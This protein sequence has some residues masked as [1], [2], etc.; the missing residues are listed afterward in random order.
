MRMHTYS[1]LCTFVKTR[2]RWPLRDYVLII[3]HFFDFPVADRVV[4]FAICKHIKKTL[5]I[6]SDTYSGDH[7]KVDVCLPVPFS[8]LTIGVI[9]QPR[10]I[11]PLNL[12][13]TV[14]G[15]N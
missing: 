8:G 11:S 13:S 14:I 2:F 7:I 12:L 15:E 9:E 4:T 3:F 5:S 1:V 10:E 6:S